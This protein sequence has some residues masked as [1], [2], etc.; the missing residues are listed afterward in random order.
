MKN[1]TTPNDGLM[2]DEL[3]LQR[4]LRRDN[5]LTIVYEKRVFLLSVLRFG[6]PFPS[7]FDRVLVEQERT[8][9]LK[10]I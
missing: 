7:R 6:D 9:C 5:F 10:K 2:G 4:D 8:K 3:F 1:Y